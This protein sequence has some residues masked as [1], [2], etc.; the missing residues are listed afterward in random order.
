[1]SGPLSSQP[2]NVTVESRAHGWRVDHY[3][4]RL[5]P[6]YSRAL[7]Q[8]AIEQQAVLVNGLP[9][10]ASRRLRVND[11]LSVRLPVK[12]DE[13]LPPDDIPLDIVF[14]DDSL[15]VINK[16]AG[17]ITH[18]GKAHYRGTLAGALQFHFN[19]LSDVAGALRPGI[20]HR[21]DRDTSGLLVVAKDN[22]VHHRLS[23][24]FERREV[25]KEYRAIA[26][27]VIQRDRDVIDTY[28]RVNPQAR[29]K[30]MVCE[31]EG[32]ARHAVTSYEVLERFYDF[33]WVRLLPR[34][35]RTHQ[36]RVH[37]RHL[38]H[39]I[40]AD[41]LYGGRSALAR[42]Y[43]DPA[44][45]GQRNS[46]KPPVIDGQAD[47]LIARQ[48]LHAYRLAF[49]H[50]VTD[51]PVEFEAPLPADIENTLAALRNTVSHTML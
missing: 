40:V 13:A 11:V 25:A 12:P 31:P 30:M 19:T 17:M 24:Q 33:T 15:V 16:P 22:Q 38:G 42:S 45:L 37:L 44:H 26:W 23:A 47:L 4:T 3:L 18:P 7:F 43:L 8:K 14:E 2:Q 21:L 46:S 39:P 35:G 9:V 41:R 48:A 49:R 10:K 50:P 28:V 51:Q 36:L 20:V 34:T 29:E 1:M 6:N 5:F 32:K 27:G